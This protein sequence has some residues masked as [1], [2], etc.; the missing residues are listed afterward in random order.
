MPLLRR[1]HFA[2][3]HARQAHAPSTQ[4][5]VGP[6]GRFHFRLRAWL[7]REWVRLLADRIRSP[8]TPLRRL[9]NGD[10]RSFYLAPQRS[11]EIAVASVREACAAK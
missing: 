8:S 1:D 9:A 10:Y 4:A 2:G 11:V 5:N 3:L 7:G 6:A